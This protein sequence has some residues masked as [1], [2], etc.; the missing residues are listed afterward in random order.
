MTAQLVF[1]SQN[2]GKIVEVKSWLAPLGVVVKSVADFENTKTMDVAETAASF[3]GNAELK[4]T[5]YAEILQL[6]V[7][8]DDSGLEV[9]VLNNEPGVASN[10]WFTGTD[11]DR[12]Q[13][14][15]KRLLEFKDRSARFVTTLCFYDPKTK[16]KQF[17]DGAVEGK[18]ALQP[19]GVSGFG[20]DP[21]FVPNGYTQSF[22]EL[23][24]EIKNTLSHRAKALE[25]FAKWLDQS[26]L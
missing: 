13:A 16:E 5:E 9:T 7:L 1:A 2:Q 3:A 18:I 12:N 15:L 26:S 20:Y 19:T 8:A 24:I 6:P 21:I 22:G 25:K 4:A 11:A 23:G 10:R 17:F 14:L